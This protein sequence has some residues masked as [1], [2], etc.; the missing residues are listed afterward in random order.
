[1]EP[2]KIDN[3]GASFDQDQIETT[4]LASRKSCFEECSSSEYIG[5]GPIHSEAFKTVAKKDIHLHLYS[6]MLIKSNEKSIS[7]NVR[8]EVM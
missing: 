7:T 8:P 2:D 3:K 5:V 6:S 4:D 1:M